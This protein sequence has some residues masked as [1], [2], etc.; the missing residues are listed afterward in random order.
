M[1]VA[2]SRAAPAGPEAPGSVA[3]DFEAVPGARVPVA[4][5]TLPSYEPGV[6]EA[7]GLDRYGLRVVDPDPILTVASHD[8]GEECFVLPRNREDARAAVAA[9]SA[10]DGK[11]WDDFADELAPMEGFLG[12]LLHRPPLELGTSFSE[13]LPAALGALGLR[14][15]RLNELLRALPMALRDLLDDHFETAALKAALA[16]PVLTGIRLGPRDPGTA[17]LFLHNH[18]FASGGPGGWIRMFRGG[19]EAVRRA[20]LGA[21]QVADA[22]VLQPSPGVRRIVLEPAR[23]GVRATGVELTDGRTIRAGTVIADQSPEA[24][25]LRW[26]GAR[27]LPPDFVH[28]VRCFRY[29]GVAARVGIALSRLPRW[30]GSPPGVSPEH[31]PRYAGIIQVGADLEVLERAADAWKYGE[32]AEKP[33]VLAAFPS[34]HDPG[35]AP[36]GRHVLAATVQAVPAAAGAPLREQVAESAL[37]ALKGPFPEIRQVVEG[38]R[39]LTPSDLEANFGLAGGSFYQ[40]EPTLDQLYSMRP[41]PGFARHRTPVAGLYLTGPASYPY[42]GLHGISGRNAARAVG[43]DRSS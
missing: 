26:V 43:E 12:R 10:A 8:G 15:R 37:G 19:A 33:L 34:I 13:A 22:E 7:L 36:E 25:F 18:A 17:G 29:R 27:N 35:L 6:A 16:G 39:V 14:G 23:G 9:R 5:E 20:L 42:G 21:V 41:V 11:A 40:G 31:D 32:M 28:N 1:L 30:R 2:D 38:L 24:V 3:S 4:P